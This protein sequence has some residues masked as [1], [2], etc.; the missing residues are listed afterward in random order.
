MLIIVFVVSSGTELTFFRTV[1]PRFYLFDILFE[2]SLF[3]G[4]LCRVLIRDKHKMI[5]I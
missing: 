1:E 2:N 5:F 3:K 4:L